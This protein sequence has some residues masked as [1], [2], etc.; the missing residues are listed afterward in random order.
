MVA[1]RP[2]DSLFWVQPTTTGRAVVNVHEHFELL[3]S[4]RRL[5]YWALS[6]F[7]W[8]LW[9]LNAL[10]REQQL[11]LQ[12][13]EMHLKAEHQQ[14]RMSELQRRLDASHSD[15]RKMRDKYL[16]RLDAPAPSGGDGV[17]AS[18]DN[19]VVLT[20]APAKGYT[21]TPEV[22]DEP[23]GMNAV[24]MLWGISSAACA[25]ALW[26]F[27][28]NARRGGPER[29]W[30]LLLVAALVCF[31]LMTF[32]GRRDPSAPILHQRSAA[33]LSAVNMFLVGFI[34]CYW[35]NDPPVRT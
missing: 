11:Q 7:L 31:L 3:T 19:K 9:I 35:L 14:I 12:L 17:G 13:Q 21:A 8:P 10:R 16:K 26:Y 28:R 15:M 20:T 1:E 27:F 33:L 23:S 32:T 4:A 2:T 25:Y 5:V 34:F 18:D 24:H 6:W 30:V 22:C 29:E